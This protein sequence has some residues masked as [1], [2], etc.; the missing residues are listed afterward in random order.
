MLILLGVRGRRRICRHQPGHDRRPCQCFN[1]RQVNPY[2]GGRLPFPDQ[3]DPIAR[4]QLGRELRVPFP[5][6]K[7]EEHFQGVAV[8]TAGFV[9][10]Q[11]V[12]YAF[13]DRR[14]RSAGSGPSDSP[15]DPTFAHRQV[16]GRAVKFK[17]NE[18]R[19]VDGSWWQG[20]QGGSSPSLYRRAVCSTE[21]SRWWEVRRQDEN[22]SC[23]RADRTRW[24]QLP[25]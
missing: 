24:G 21:T 6:A 10:G 15:G 13:A 22:I 4:D 5:V 19:M 14:S 17:V 18:L 8:G 7:R 9:R 16:S 20:W 12:Q 2:R 1:G 25:E 11:A 3:R 23:P